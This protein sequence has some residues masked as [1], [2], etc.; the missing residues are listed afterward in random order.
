MRQKIKDTGALVHVCIPND[1]TR[2]ARMHKQNK[3]IS[4][5]GGPSYLPQPPGCIYPKSDSH[6][7]R[8]VI[9]VDM[10]RTFPIPL[11]IPALCGSSMKAPKD[12]RPVDA[13]P[14]NPLKGLGGK[15]GVRDYPGYV[16]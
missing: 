1:F 6:I 3:P 11:D 12:C 10:W 2:T 8:A 14:M 9:F 7:C 16:C 5:L 13:S 15:V 4:R